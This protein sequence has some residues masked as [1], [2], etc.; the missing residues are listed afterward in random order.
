MGAGRDDFERGRRR[1]GTCH[2]GQLATARKAISAQKR[3]VHQEF[4]PVFGPVHVR[5][6]P[7]KLDL[8]AFE[9][10]A[11]ETANLADIQ[12]R[13]GRTGGAERDPHELQPRQ[14]LKRAGR[15]NLE[16]VGPH[17]CVTLV[18]HDFEAVDHGT[19]RPHKI[20]TYA[21][22]QI[23]GEFNVIHGLGDLRVEGM[24][25]KG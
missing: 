13:S 24:V 19:Q 25:F 3:R 21:A 10:S 16:G 23:R 9:K 1:I 8:S 5:R 2:N 6:L 20:V 4:G 22:D 12:F 15:N 17:R 18:L 14:R 11:D 7:V